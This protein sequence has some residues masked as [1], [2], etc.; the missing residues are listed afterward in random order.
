[1]ASMGTSPTVP[2]AVL[3]HVLRGLGS[4]NCR[5]TRPALRDGKAYRFR[6]AI[7]GEVGGEEV[8]IYREGTLRVGHSTT[9]NASP[10]VAEL[11][12][13]LMSLYESPAARTRIMNRLAAVNL[14][15]LP[16]ALKTEAAQFVTR[17]R[18]PRPKAAPVQIT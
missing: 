15:A 3:A 1:M 9:E 17:L 4:Q 6:L 16:E 14:D 7:S 10:N 12:A 18:R 13:A 2:E 11:V 5:R 8:S